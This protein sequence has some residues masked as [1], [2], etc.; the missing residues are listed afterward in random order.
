[1]VD[2][3][4]LLLIDSNSL[5]HRA[6]H[7]LPSLTNKKGD[8][9]GAVYGFLLVFFRAIKDLNPYFIAAAFDVKGP[10]FRHKEFKLYKAQRPKMPSELSQQIPKIKKTLESFGVPIFEKKGFEADDIIGTIAKKINKEK[11]SFKTEVIIMSGDKD[12]FQLIDSDIK[13]YGLRKGVKDIIIYDEEK[14]R[15]KYQGLRPNQLVDFKGLRG[16]PSDNIVGV[17]GIG[18]KTGIKL[19]KEFEYLEVMYESLERETQKTKNINQKIKE[20]LLC[21]KEQAFLSKKLVQ[22][23]CDV[24]I[25]F[26]L[27]KCKFGRYDKEGVEKVLKEFEFN[28]LIKKIPDLKFQKKIIF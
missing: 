11:D 23:K 16:D 15:E 19:I 6:F 2:K 22:I 12:L 26:E 21:Y 5:I 9:L 28:S 17:P 10:T 18:D 1:M 4:K 3:K 7:A 27:E 25:A 14:I 8:Q 13:V 20:K 24:P